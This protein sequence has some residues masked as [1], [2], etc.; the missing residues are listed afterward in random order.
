M[1]KI[2]L[3]SNTVM[4][5]RVSVYNYF[6]E[7]FRSRGYE[8]AVLADR[9]QQGR[10]TVQFPFKALPFR[11][12]LYRDEIRRIEPD[13]VILFLHLKD[14]VI[15]PLVHWLKRE[16]IPF[17]FW[18]KGANLD[19][20]GNLLKNAVFHHIQHL[21]SGIILYS[22]H[23]MPF[24]RKKDRY[25]VTVANNTINHFE[26]PAI[27]DSKEKIKGDLKIGFKKVALFVGRMDAGLKNRKKADHAVEIFR[28]IKNPGYGLVLV[29]SGMS[30]E[31]LARMNRDNTMY[32]GE[33]HDP[34]NVLISRL[35]KM[36]DVFLMPGH[37]GLSLNQAFF[38][39]LPVLTEEGKQP[40]EVHYLVDGRN[41]FIVK[42]ND[43]AGLKEKLLYLFE[44]DAER[45]RLG[46]NARRDLLEKASIDLMFK[47]FLENI[48]RLDGGGGTS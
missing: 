18:T 22:E 44:N 14:L 2:L 25:K 46:E 9:L 43:L 32:L 8:F 33:V 47:G 45:Q 19:D 15:F 37:V 20:P 1:K 34:A 38:W 21:S 13:Y 36:S 16:R 39:G 7:Q 28:S 48:R 17:L 12:S 29:G 30:P 26:F 11:F 23:E 24:I 40:P 42:E 35:F 10:A 3:V 31:L 4:H 27:D 6:C 41:G 5:Y